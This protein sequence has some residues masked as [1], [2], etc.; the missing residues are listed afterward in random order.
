MEN[1]LSKVVMTNGL[2]ADL[3]DLAPFY[4]MSFKI[5]YSHELPVYKTILHFIQL[6][7][8]QVKK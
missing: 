1:V 2:F 7:V 5:Y 3:E 8:V 6:S 4:I